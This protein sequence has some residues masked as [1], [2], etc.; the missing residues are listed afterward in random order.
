MTEELTSLFFRV[1]KI[2]SP[3]QSNVKLIGRCIDEL[4][5]ES[6]PNEIIEE[7]IKTKPEDFRGKARELKKGS[8]QNVIKAGRF[9]YHPALQISP[10]PPVIT[11]NDDGTFSRKEQPFFLKVKDTFTFND[12]LEYFYS[13][14]PNIDRNIKR[15]IGAIEYLYTKTAVPLVNKQG[16]EDLDALDLLLFTIDTAFTLCQDMDDKLAKVLNLTDYM[17][18]GLDVYLD[19]RENCI[20]AGTNHVI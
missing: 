18:N 12:V 3:G 10:P 9:Y 8:A 14:F 13:R 1:K 5:N 17:N 6:I 16:H 11:I 7:A 15:D 20:L 2:S 19:K 4:I